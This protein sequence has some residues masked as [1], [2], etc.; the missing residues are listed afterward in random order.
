MSRLSGM[1]RKTVSRVE[2]GQAAQSS[3]DALEAFLDKL[4]AEAEVDTRDHRTPVPE[5]VTFRVTGPRVEWEVFVSG[6]ADI[7]DDLRHQVV[8]LMKDMDSGD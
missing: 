3:T 4:D 6:P 1:D 7:A 5:E 2:A 8:E